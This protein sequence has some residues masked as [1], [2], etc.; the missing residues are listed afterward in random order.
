[1]TFAAAI[2]RHPA[3]AMA[4]GEVVGDVLEGVG[5]APDLAVVFV[6]APMTG[7]LE[8]AVRA[9]R[10]LL[11]PAC[12]VGATAHAVLAG[13]VGVEGEAAIVLWAARFDA[14]CVPV[15][16]T[17]QPDGSDG[18]SFDGIGPLADIAATNPTGSLLLFPDPFS[19]PAEDFLTA[20]AGSA[21]SLRVSGGF[22]SAGQAP[23]QNRLVL[24]DVLYTDGAVGVL[25]PTAPETVVAQACRPIGQPFIVTKAEQ[26]LIIEL[27]GRPAFERLMEIVNNLPDDERALAARG[28]HCGIVANEHASFNDAADFARGDFLVRGV[29]GANRE[30]GAIA[31]AGEVFVGSTV[32]FQ[33]RD[34][35]SAGADLASLLD[36]KRADGALVFTCTG[37]GSAMFGNPHH[38]ADILDDLLHGTG[39]RRPA[40]AGMFAAGELGPVGNR[41]AIHTFTASLSLFTHETAGF[42]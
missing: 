32:Q 11:A 16:I 41:N 5:H 30:R 10:L 25:L 1:M 8:D 40:I 36:G 19:F 22:A 28:L 2:S 26:N 15:R 4:V 18:F 9:I 39:P 6:T 7:A 27:G 42:A 24:D 33:V 38:D 37:R 12:M 17:A 21:P 3:A 20:L 14:D 34:P 13:A 23:G 35:A 29:L 31:I